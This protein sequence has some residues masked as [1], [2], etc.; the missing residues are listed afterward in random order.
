MGDVTSWATTSRS[1]KPATNLP[2]VHDDGRR[3]PA[4]AALVPVEVENDA[5]PQQEHGRHDG[6]IRRDG[7]HGGV[8]RLVQLVDQLLPDRRLHVDE[9]VHVHG[10]VVEP[11]RCRLTH[12]QLSYFT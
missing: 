11:R 8:L 9:H 4:A 5:A 3:R 10:H 7:R 6:R 1:C 12:T 2:R